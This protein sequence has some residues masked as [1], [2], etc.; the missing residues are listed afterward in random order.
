M[1]VFKTSSR[2]IFCIIRT[3]KI[4]K[5]IKKQQTAQTPDIS[6]A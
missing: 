5:D 2:N 1:D 4:G 6:T 3:I